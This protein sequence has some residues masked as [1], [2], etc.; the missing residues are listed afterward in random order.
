MAPAIYP[1][2]MGTE[3]S[4]SGIV[5]WNNTGGFQQ[6]DEK[7]L[8]LIYTAAGGTSFWSKDQPF[9]QCIAYSTDKG[10]TWT[11]YSGN[12]V[13][14][15]II[16]ENRDPKVVWYEPS[17]KWIMALFLDGNKFGLFTSDDLKSWT[18]I[19]EIT[20]K[21]GAECPD[22]FEI[23][24]DG[25]QE[26]MKWVLTAA[27]GRFLMGSF[28]G[29]QFT[30]ETESY[31][32]EWGENYYAVQSY[33]DIQDGRRIQVGWMNGSEFKGMPF[34]QQFAFPREL[35]LK[36]TREGIRLCGVPAREIETIHGK[37]QSWNNLTVKPEDN[38][39]S[40]LQGE[41]YHIVSEFT[42]NKN[43]AMEFGFNLR[44]FEVLYNT[45]NGMITAHRPTDNAVSEVKLLPEEGKIRIEILLDRASVEIY[46]NN[47]EVPMGFFYLPEDEN[48]QLSL[49]CKGGNILL[50][51]MDVYELKSI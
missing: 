17:R 6:G 48:K 20:I 1:D 8:V 2:Q 30:P 38:L 14:P 37:K 13:L 43:A 16:A 12:P 33:S 21:N 49:V 47:G 22:F 39:L 23:P 51:S 29:E 42:I 31:P 40:A 24:L 45:Q 5:D 34:N 11:K 18:Q 7:T 9:T 25:D 32:S 15:H 4:G 46:A 10:R 35:T 36:T 27:N 44:G 26:K 19:Q 41:L 3:F 50:N 28:D